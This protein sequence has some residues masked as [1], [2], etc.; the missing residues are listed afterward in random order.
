MAYLTMKII[1]PLLWTGLCLAIVVESAIAQD[2]P[3]K[4]VLTLDTSERILDSAITEAK[5]LNAPHGSFAVVD[6]AG[7]LLVFKRIDNSLPATAQVAVG[8]ART[9]AIFRMPSADLENAVHV[10]WR[11]QCCRWVHG[12]EG[13]YSAAC[14]RPGDW[15]N[16]C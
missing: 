5:R 13:W 8:K 6:D 12:Y 15:S 11:L 9:A 2:L 4:P 1:Q 14:E 7:Y 3:T 10:E 16:R